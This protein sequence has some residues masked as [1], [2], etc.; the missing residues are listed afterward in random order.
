MDIRTTLSV[1]ET[2]LEILKNC[3][4][5][6]TK[7][8]MLLDSEGIVRVEGLIKEICLTSPNPYLELESGTKVV[9]K[10]IIAI[11]GIFSPSYSEC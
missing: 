11:N 9:L 1:N 5:Q 6:K 4:E 7:A 8:A 10:T 3:Q 2:F